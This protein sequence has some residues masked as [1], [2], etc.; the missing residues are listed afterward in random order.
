[1]KKHLAIALLSIAQWL[2]KV[3]LATV[4][5]V[6][7]FCKYLINNE[8]NSR[9]KILT[10]TSILAICTIARILVRRA[11]RKRQEMMSK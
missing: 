10:V 1:M 8:P 5:L 11:A 9:R 7:K 4:R 3:P 2:L 6:V